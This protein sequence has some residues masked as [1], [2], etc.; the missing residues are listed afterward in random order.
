MA[1]ESAIQTAIV[2]AIQYVPGVVYFDPPPSIRNVRKPA[3]REAY[4]RALV[5]VLSKIYESIERHGAAALVTRHNVG[6]G[7]LPAGNGKMRPVYFNLPGQYDLSITMGPSGRLAAREVKDP[8][9][10]QK[11]DGTPGAYLSKRS[12]Q[13]DAWGE[14][15]EAMGVS[16]GVWRSSEEAIEDMRRMLDNERKMRAAA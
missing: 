14:I 5:V 15:Y 9:R 4:R 12:P 8:E 13:Q 1:N 2:N 3:A 6:A 16:H 10:R 7:S 11:K